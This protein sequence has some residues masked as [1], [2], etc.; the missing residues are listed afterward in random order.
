[1]RKVMMLLGAIGACLAMS[2]SAATMIFETPNGATT[3][4]GPVDARVQFDLGAGSLQITI[5][6]LQDNPTDVMQCVSGLFFTLSSEGSS[7]SLTTLQGLERNIAANGTYWPVVG[8]VG[9]IA[10]PGWLLSGSSLPGSGS[11]WSLNALGGGQPEHTIIGGPNAL[12]VYSAANGSIAGNDPHNPF[13]AGPATFNLSITGVTADTT[14][15]DVMFQF[16]TAPG[17]N[18]GVPDGGSS[19]VLLG[20]ALSGLSLLKRR[21]C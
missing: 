2:T 3:G 18:V 20:M 13:L 8:S 19:L 7:G 14:V 21:F 1:M 12:G 6:N 16:G 4:G 11:T 10:T 5:W 9:P 17:N 15:T